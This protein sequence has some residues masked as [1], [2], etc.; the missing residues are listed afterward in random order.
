VTRWYPLARFC[1]FWRIPPGDV[2]GMPW[3]QFVAFQLI[4]ADEIDRANRATRRRKGR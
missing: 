2:L 1:R 4:Q 3:D